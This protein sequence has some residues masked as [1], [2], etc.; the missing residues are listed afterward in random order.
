ML[1][2]LKFSVVSFLLRLRPKT[3]FKASTFFK[4]FRFGHMKEFMCVTEL[5]SPSLVTAANKAQY[6]TKPETSG[7]D[8]DCFAVEH[9]G[10]TQHICGKTVNYMCLFN[11]G[12]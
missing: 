5:T 6:E 3:S 12:L 8:T 4:V 2:F 10:E 7:P 11:S 1:I 9:Q